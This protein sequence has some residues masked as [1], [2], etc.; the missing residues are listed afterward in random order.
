MRMR[1]AGRKL[2]IANMI[3]TA[4]RHGPTPA[5]RRG[6]SSK[7]SARLTSPISSHRPDLEASGSAVPAPPAAPGPHKPSQIAQ[8][9]ALT[10]EF[11]YASDWIGVITAAT[12]PPSA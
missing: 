8:Y 2:W 3:W 12:A 11:S 1:V 9:A 5:V 6:D 4:H 7:E 10:W